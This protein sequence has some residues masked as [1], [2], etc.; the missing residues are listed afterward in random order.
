[1]APDCK[2]PILYCK[3][4]LTLSLICCIGFCHFPSFKPKFAHCSKR[5]PARSWTS[6]FS[7]RTLEWPR[8]RTWNGKR[9]LAHYYALLRL[10]LTPLFPFNLQLQAVQLRRSNGFGQARQQGLR[11]LQVPGQVLPALRTRMGRRPLWDQL[12][13]IGREDEESEEGPGF[14]STLLVFQFPKPQKQPF[15]YR[16]A[17]LNEAVIRKCPRWA[18]FISALIFD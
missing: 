5:T 10:S 13:G 6:A 11:M 17:K 3:F 1:M 2:N 15:C 14:V 18:S 12:R 16:E 9:R 7:R 4:R 8:S